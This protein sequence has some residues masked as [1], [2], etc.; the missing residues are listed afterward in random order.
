MRGWVWCFAMACTPRAARALAAPSGAASAFWDSVGAPTRV[1]AP[2]VAQSELAFRLLTKAHGAELAYTPML[3]ARQFVLA[4]EKAR[5]AQYDGGRAGSRDRPLVAQLCGDDAPTLV[6]AAERVVAQ[7]AGELDAVDL[8]L[9]CPQ[10]IAKKGHYGAYLLTEPAAFWRGRISPED[11]SELSKRLGGREAAAD[12][13]SLGPLALDLAV[14][15]I[16][17]DDWTFES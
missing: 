5:H 6:A 4:R 9:G 3:H 8:N 12:P 1:C 15:R 7:S 10:K 16:S 11:L 17:L 14:P 2:M 13:H